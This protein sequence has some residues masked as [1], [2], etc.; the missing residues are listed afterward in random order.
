MAYASSLSQEKF[1]EIYNQLYQLSEKQGKSMYEAKL[2]KAKTRKQREACA[3][4]YR[5]EWFELFD[6]WTRDKY[7]NIYVRDCIANGV[8]IPAEVLYANDHQ[9]QLT[10]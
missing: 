9:A 1:N 4:S 2:A 5:G 7:S 8:V 10:F 3:G 6:G